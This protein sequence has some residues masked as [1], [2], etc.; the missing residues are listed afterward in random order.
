MEY[1]EAEQRVRDALTEFEATDRYLLENN[2]S[3]R[4]I[5]ARLAFHLQRMFPEY[6]VDVEY[7]RAGDT[8]KRLKVPEE[9]ANALDD[10]GRA[11]V[12]P[13]VI[14]HRRGPDGPN[15]IGLEL[16]K[17]TDPRGPDCD[18]ERIR[19]LTIGLSYVYGAL[20]ECE[21][22]PHQEHCIRVVEWLYG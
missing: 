12:V 17:T 18:R 7:N 20:L 14:V 11:L 10:E 6:H 2:L 5:A 1:P 4:C 9:C 16:K 19:A 8:P 22:R 13:D 21:T 15:L 3:E